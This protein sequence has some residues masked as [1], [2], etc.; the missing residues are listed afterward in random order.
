MRGLTP[1]RLF[2]LAA[3]TEPIEDA[4]S[5]VALVDKTVSVDGESTTTQS[6]PDLIAA[7]K[8]TAGNSA[9]RTDATFGLRFGRL[10]PPGACN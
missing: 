10:V 7:A 5:E 2:A 8:F 6:L 9:I 4:I 3:M 1:S